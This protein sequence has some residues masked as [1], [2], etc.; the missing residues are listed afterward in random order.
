MSHSSRNGNGYGSGSGNGN[1]NGDYYGSSNSSRNKSGDVELAKR[2]Q[3][4]ED[5]QLALK[6]QENAQEMPAVQYQRQQPYAPPHYQQPPHMPWNA[7]QELAMQQRAME[8]IRQQN[9]QDNLLRA[10]DEHPESLTHI[11]MLYVLVHI[12]SKAVR[13]FVDTGAQSSVMSLVCAQRVG[14][15]RFINT[16]FGGVAKGIGEQRILGVCLS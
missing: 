4:E 14:I 6:L 8:A 7:A 15:D 1:G 13:A 10:L 5:L 11:P 9:L 3:E 2:L 16:S 12:N